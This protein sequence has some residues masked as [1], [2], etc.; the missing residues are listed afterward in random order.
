MLSAGEN[1]RGR[2]SGTLYIGIDNPNHPDIILY[3]GDNLLYRC[4][5]LGQAARFVPPKPGM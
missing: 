4:Q 3:V 5:T 2:K 1:A